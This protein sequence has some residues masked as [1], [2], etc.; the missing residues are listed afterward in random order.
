MNDYYGV[1]YVCMFL[2]LEIVNWIDYDVELSFK[3]FHTL[4]GS[5][6]YIGQL[7]VVIVVSIFLI[8]SLLFGI[9][10]YTTI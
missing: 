3:C 7:D 6:F 5:I 2:V 9:F 8:T 4:V 1:V 10:K